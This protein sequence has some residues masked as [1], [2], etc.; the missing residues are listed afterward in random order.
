MNPFV[1]KL[2]W[3]WCFTTATGI[4]MKTSSMAGKKNLQQYLQATGYSIAGCQGNI[5]HKVREICYRLLQ[6]QI[7]KQKETLE[8]CGGL[9]SALYNALILNKETFKFHFNFHIIHA[10]YLVAYSFQAFRSTRTIFILSNIFFNTNRK[11]WLNPQ[12]KTESRGT[13]KQLS[14]ITELMM[15]SRKRSLI[16]Q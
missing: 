15:K 2:L 4:L 1:P 16:S 7:E 5:T 13:L 8:K 11:T 3:L 14:N 12:S 6:T 10:R 9:W